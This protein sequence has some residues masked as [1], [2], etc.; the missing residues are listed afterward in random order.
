MTKNPPLQIPAVVP[1][2]GFY[3]H[4]KHNSDGS[5]ENYAYEVLN[6]GIHT[7]EDCRPEDANLVIYR[8]LYEDAAVYKAGGFWDARPL[9]MWM[10]TVEKDGHTV[11]RFTRITDPAVIAE[12]QMQSA[13]M[14]GAS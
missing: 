10:G 12:L 2:I 13:K 7:E 11:L 3:Y 8:P 14:Y 4:Y 9:T 1:E 5:V 6:V